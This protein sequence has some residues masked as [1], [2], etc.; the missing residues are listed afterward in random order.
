MLI[1]LAQTTLTFSA[2]SWLLLA[3]ILL[4]IAYTL[5]IYRRTNP[6]VSALVRGLLISSRV[7]AICCLLFVVF[8]ATFSLSSTRSEP[9]V[10][11]IAV[12]NSASMAVQDKTGARN[13]KIRSVLHDNNL[14][15]LEKKFDLKF[16]S[17]SDQ[18]RELP[19]QEFDS[20][21]F[22]GDVT[23]IAGSL[24]SI[25]GEL[26][27]EN[28]AGIVLLSDGNYNQGGNPIRYASEIGVPIYSIGIGSNETK[29]DLALTDI[30][31]NPFAY[32]GEPTPITMT[33][34]SLGFGEQKTALTLRNEQSTIS[35][36]IITIPPSPSEIQIPIRYSPDSPGRQ[37][38]SIELNP[39]ANE[40]TL[41]NNKRTFYVDV[42]KSHL[43]VLL[44]AGKASPDISFL[45]RHLSASERYKVHSIVE[46]G[47]GTFYRMPATSSLP[48]HLQDVDLFVLYD[49]PTNKTAPDLLN[50]LRVAVQTQAKPV[51]FVL[52][53]ETA[54]QRLGDLEQF[55]PVMA[56]SQNAN[57][58]QVYP[59]LSPLAQSHPV[60]QIGAER[61]SL[62]ASWSQLPPVFTSN[63]FNQY[64]PNSEI[65]VYAIPANAPAARKDENKKP[66]L[67]VRSNGP[68]K[69]AALLAY[70]IWRWD[71]LMWGIGNADDM[72]SQL[73]NNLVRWIESTK[74]DEL[75]R[76]EIEK[77]NFHYGEPVEIK[78]EV[79]NDKRMP[80]S[81]ADVKILLRHQTAQDELLATRIGDGK[82]NLTVHPEQPGDY[83]V[84]A[85]AQEGSRKLGE[86][87]VLFSI[88]EYSKELTDLRIQ[89]ALLRS[90]SESSGGKYISPDSLSDLTW[91]I[92]GEAKAISES[93][94]IEVWNDP[95]TLIAIVLLLSAEWFVRKR[96]GMV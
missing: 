37:K 95:L 49:F 38:L 92:G 45:R 76:V 93:K 18:S 84:S 32:V 4:A 40:Q 71:L 77:T 58:I 90:I 7:L 73:I 91:A 42:L 61:G 23:N 94:E 68:Q 86:T 57:E 22:R 78:I 36:Q 27:E 85:I 24:E 81:D 17:F 20:L 11:A 12:D 55:L 28:L 53:R 15:Q 44:L 16:Y 33:V 75:V 51:L 2:Q 74:A 9:P 63:V 26:T 31:A 89:E 39:I 6:I 66:L 10:L 48:E 88:G 19:H 82:Y 96:K 34:R 43:Q 3:A 64:W 80:I 52:G 25:K 21:R 83:I 47:D 8:E 87:D 67:L 79:F 30:D 62:A 41:E 1:L 54:P 72:F 65:L 5:S 59:L 29:P 14:K 70:G 50:R 60:T 46:K 69:S 35:S 13:E 56:K